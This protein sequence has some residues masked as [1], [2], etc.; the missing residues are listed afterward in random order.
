MCLSE[1]CVY[2]CGVYVVCVICLRCVVYA[3]CV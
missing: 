2:E 1:V 3:M